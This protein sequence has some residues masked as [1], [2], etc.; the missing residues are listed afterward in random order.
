M[1]ANAKPGRHPQAAKTGGLSSSSPSSSSFAPQSSHASRGP[2]GRVGTPRPPLPAVPAP[3]AQGPRPACHALP[4]RLSCPIPVPVHAGPNESARTGPG[5]F[6]NPSGPAA[7]HRSLASARGQRA[8]AD[9]SAGSPRLIAR[10][11]RRPART[12]DRSGDGIG[13]PHP[14]FTN[15]RGV[16]PERLRLPPLGLRVAVSKRWPA[17]RDGSSRKR[18][19]PPSRQISF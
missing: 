2:G 5:I 7:R 14:M 18:C 11:Y 19:E 16:E 6:M 9:P 12:D 3:G 15:T 17:K 13:F 10:E 1:G 4:G 8:G